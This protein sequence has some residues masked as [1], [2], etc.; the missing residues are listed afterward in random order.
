MEM[1]RIA[2][3]NERSVRKR[4]WKYGINSFEGYLEEVLQRFRIP[5]RSYDT[6]MEALS[7]EPDILIAALCEESA[8]SA[9]SLLAYAETGGTVVSYAGIGC[10]AEKLGYEET[11]LIGSGYA[12]LEE[13]ERPLRYLA[14]RPWCIKREQTP[15]NR[16]RQA[17]TL[18]EGSPSGRKCG[19]ALLSIPVG[20]G[21]VERWSVDI[22]ASIVAMQQGLGPVIDDGMAVPDGTI[23]VRDDILK[24]DDRCAM[25]W[26]YDRRTTETGMHYFPFP[27]ADW[28]CEA[29][30]RHL[31]AIG[32][33]KS[34]TLPFA[35]FW[36]SGIPSVVAISHDSDI[37]NDEHAHSAL[38]LL[39]ETG[40]R[41]TWCMLEP[42]YSSSVYD[43]AKA[44]G[45]EIALHY[46]ALHLEG[47]VWSEETFRD[48][49]V[50]LKRTAQVDRIASNKNHYTRFEGWSD[51]YRWCERYGI[52]A[53]QTR[54]PSKMGNIGLLFG[55]CHPY[56]P[57]GD[58]ID[59]N[60]LYDVLEIGFLSQD[61]NHPALYDA[62]VIDP[63]MDSVQQVGGVAHFLFHQAHLHRYEEV[64]QALRDVILKA[65]QRGLAI[66]TIEEINNWE[67]TRR[68]LW[69]ADV[70]ESGCPI[71]EGTIPQQPLTIYVPVPIDHLSESAAYETILGAPCIPIVLNI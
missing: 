52:E 15:R 51:L 70:D 7:S 60:R 32:L 20:N 21:S 3:V 17:G 9:Q 66:W 56:C 22:T 23:P 36:P 48:Q 37:N 55:T 61:L 13:F 54:G 43:E 63:F 58:F 64:R 50:W 10:L 46:N 33:G 41:S 24:A 40:I 35:A 57:I 45:H 25:D 4:R 8:E 27:Y 62:S 59:E 2:I 19:S 49:A 6:L 53:D 29:I 42:G 68:N 69:I 1:A 65:R 18:A 16:D 28:W 47:G 67:R 26:E 5:F 12:L 11:R 34:K 44:D 71:F 30:A 14:A 31:I 39:R 38:A